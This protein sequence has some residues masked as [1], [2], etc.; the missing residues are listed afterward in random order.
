M[1]N[2]Y[3]RC[4]KCFSALVH[5]N[6]ALECS[7][8]KSCYKC[9]NDLAIFN[10]ENSTVSSDQ[11]NVYYKMYEDVTEEVYWGSIREIALAENIIDFVG[12]NFCDI[13][14]V[15]CGDGYLLKNISCQRRL[16]NYFALDISL[17]R[18]S[19]IRGV[20]DN[21]HLIKGNIINLPFKDN[22][23]DYTICSE[24]LEHVP[25]YEQALKELIR[26]TKRNLIITVPNDQEPTKI[27]CPHCN[28]I[29]YLSGHINQFNKENLSAVLN[30]L[31][32]IKTYKFKAFHT[33]FTYN[34]ATLKMPRLLRKTFDSSV[35]S[36]QKIFSFLKPN[37]LLIYIEKK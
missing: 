36:L 28:Q 18:I 13:L 3:Y 24:V 23:F 7:K 20:N 16:K 34:K 29:H 22:L 30:K 6:D 8:C 27:I 10:N 31:D 35:I 26:V 2:N 5:K 1:H 33:I 14:E 15:G 19:K 21:A 37:F 32:S 9:V 12:K 11:D 4:I 17:D 25:D